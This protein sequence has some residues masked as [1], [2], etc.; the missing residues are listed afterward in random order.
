[1]PPATSAPISTAVPAVSSG[2]PQQSLFHLSQIPTPVAARSR[3][4]TRSFMFD[5]R[6]ERTQAHPA[7]GI[8]AGNGPGPAKNAPGG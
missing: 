1:M 7:Y 3:G 8:G 6:S 5:L 2:L 4:Q